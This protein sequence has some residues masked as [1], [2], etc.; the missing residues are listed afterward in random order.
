VLGQ[1]TNVGDLMSS[2]L[3]Y[4]GIYRNLLRE[5]EGEKEC[6]GA[7]YVIYKKLRYIGLAFALNECDWFMRARK[8]DSSVHLLLY[9]TIYILL[10]LLLWHYFANFQI[11]QNII[12]LIIFDEFIGKSDSSSKTWELEFQDLPRSSLEAWDCCGATV[13]RFR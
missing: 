11:C 4:I 8:R 1:V 7:R 10:L 9:T 5:E 3:F 2:R 12:P 13:L 6:T